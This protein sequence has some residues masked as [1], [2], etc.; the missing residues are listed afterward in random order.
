MA[1]SCM[2]A[3]MIP[4]FY[5]E[6]TEYRL[7]LDKVGLLGGWNKKN[8]NGDRN[9][10]EGYSPRERANRATVRGVFCAVGIIVFVY[11]GS[12][13]SI[14]AATALPDPMVLTKP[15]AIAI[16][17]G[18]MLSSC[19]LAYFSV[20][21]P[22]WLGISY[23]SQN[24]VDFYSKQLS[25]K[26]P[27]EL[28][29]R[30]CWSIL[31]H[32]FLNY[33]FLIAYFCNES[34][35][36][37]VLS[38][39]VGITVG[40]GVVYFVWLGHTKLNYRNRT[41]IAVLLSLII[42]CA[43]ALAFSFGCMFV[44]TVWLDN[45]EYTGE[46]FVFTFF[47]WLA[48]CVLAH[49]VYYRLTKR[50][51]AEA[52][53]LRTTLGD[54]TVVGDASEVLSAARRE[55]LEMTGEWRYNRQVFQPP[56]SI[57]CVAFASHLHL[58][59]MGRKS[60]Q[61]SNKSHDADDTATTKASIE[62]L[63]ETNNHYQE[64]PPLSVQF[65]NS[66]ATNCVASGS[67]QEATEVMETSD[68]RCSQ[69]NIS[70]SSDSPPTNDDNS[71]IGGENESLA[72]R[73]IEE[74]E[75]PSLY[76]MMKQNSCCCRRRHY[77]APRQKGWSLWFMVVRWTLWTLACCWHLGFTVV[78]IGA[79]YQQNKVRGALHETYE[80]LYPTNY[81]TGVMC[82][83]D[84]ASPDADIRTFDSLSDVTDAGYTVIHCGACGSCSNWNDL[85]L[86]WTTREHLAQKAKNCVTKSILGT[87]EDVQTC[88]EDTIGFTEECSL[89]WTNDEYC[90]RDNCMFIFLQSLFTN[91]VNNFQVGPDDIT[92]ATCDEAL[93]GP[94]FVP[95]SG[96]T[97]R[98]MN[99]ISDISRPTS[100]QCGVASEDWS[101]VFDFP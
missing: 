96:A 38:T 26:S 88:N 33:P 23:S 49:A 99:I 28:S 2:W 66:V 43:S 29:F 91:Q 97:R 98:R 32:F 61:P 31:G 30:V 100:Q 75:I 25:T 4:H 92:S 67:D 53:A 37:V 3:W 81:T 14:G 5:I 73:S 65:G 57:N 13:L 8:N 45:N 40:F 59:K 24:H 7:A 72:T 39:G 74:P 84:K 51:L 63:R 20:E 87:R 35:S 83:W 77:E 62:K 9:D 48:L 12:A 93:C 58:V 79:S 70:T 60:A 22:R 89:C 34:I 36:H 44:K 76:S 41:R 82:A 27:R 6:F 19:L 54:D 52:K 16:G 50:K 55:E 42:A 90:A 21:L 17:V 56:K 85:G 1:I 95:C 69:S 64:K 101:I 47:V 80:N 46:Y 94:R 10:S 86:Q 18:R 78:N 11:V 68:H 15:V 71:S